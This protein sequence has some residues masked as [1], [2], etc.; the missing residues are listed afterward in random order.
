LINLSF[1]DGK[2][3]LSGYGAHGKIDQPA[4]SVWQ[5]YQ[6]FAA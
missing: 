2:I 4:S 3:S 5:D 6:G 1:E